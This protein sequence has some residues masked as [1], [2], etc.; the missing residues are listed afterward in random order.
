VM[1]GAERAAL[2]ALF[3]QRESVLLRL[4]SREQKQQQQH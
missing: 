4:E 2:K 1:I 3:C